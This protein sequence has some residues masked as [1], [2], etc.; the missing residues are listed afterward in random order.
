M[1]EEKEVMSMEQFEQLFALD[2]ESNKNQAFNYAIR[3][4]RNN[5]TTFSGVK[6]DFN[7]L[8]EKYKLYYDFTLR[9]NSGKDTK[10]ISKLDKRKDII[11]FIANGMYNSE[12]GIGKEPRDNYMIGK[13]SFTEFKTFA[14][15]FN[16]LLAERDPARIEELRL[17]FKDINYVTKPKIETSTQSNEF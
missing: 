14:Q 10:Y 1:E 15:R 11:T 9:K 4:L 8:F 6:I 13:L 3:F 2:P 5:P 17:T 7:F 12:W 16:A